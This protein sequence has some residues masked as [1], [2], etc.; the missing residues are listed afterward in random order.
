MFVCFSSDSANSVANRLRSAP[1]HI[2]DQRTIFLLEKNITRLGRL[3]RRRPAPRLSSAIFYPWSRCL[4]RRSGVSPLVV[5]VVVVVVVVFA[6]AVVMTIFTFVMLLSLLLL[7]LLL[8]F[9]LF[10]V[11]LGG[12]GWS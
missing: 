9:F 10:E 4:R 6:L 3:H 7:L 5:V 1:R 8:Y 11:V 12:E 2:I